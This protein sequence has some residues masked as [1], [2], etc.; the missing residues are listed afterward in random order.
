MSEKIWVRKAEISE[1]LAHSIEDFL[2]D[3]IQTPI[4]GTPTEV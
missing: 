4:Y 3:G 1:G 2:E